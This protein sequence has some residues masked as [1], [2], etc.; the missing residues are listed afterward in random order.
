[1]KLSNTKIVLIIILIS[2]LLR[3]FLAS[4]LELGNDEVYYWTYALYPDWSHYDHP[5]MVGLFIQLFSLNLSLD[6]EFFIRLA[7]I[8]SGSFCAYLIYLIAKEIKDE[9]TGLISVLLYTSSFYATVITGVFILPDTPLCLFWLISLNLM[10][11]IIK[12][13]SSEKLS[14]KYLILLGFTIVFAILSKY[15]GI[16][17]WLG[18][19]SYLL[20][21]DRSKMRSRSFL[22]FN[23]ICLLGLAP[24]LYWNFTN[25]FASFQF[26]SGRIGLETFSFDGFFKELG[27]EL[28]YHNP[29]VYI[30]LWIGFFS[31]CRRRLNIQPK[32]I[33]LLFFISLPLIFMVFAV[34]LFRPS[35]PHWSGPAYLTLL[36]LPA[37]YI[38]QK[39]SVKL[40]YGLISFCVLILFSGLAI[41]YSQIK[42][43]LFKLDEPHSMFTKGQNDPSLDMVGWEQLADQFALGYQQDLKDKLI[44]KNTVLISDRWFPAAHLDYYV[45][46][47]LGLKL[48]LIGSIEDQHKYHWINAERGSMAIG[49]DAYYIT[50]ST[51]YN[52]PKDYFSEYFEFID[53]SIGIPI[54][55]N[56]EIVKYAFVYHLHSLKKNLW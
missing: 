27:G 11:N 55:R 21:Y 43:G 51:M 20:F 3:G 28:I 46:R 4:V 54:L 37:I 39:S 15:S 52:N 23:L 13:D 18:F 42:N 10:L 44:D 35:L 33:R 16:L 40:R 8:V 49:D 50:L 45:A 7:S 34:S 24:I 25:D 14:S 32:Y 38:Q 41:G 53:L 56:D 22:I 1:M 48:L 9:K 6:S 2:A 19:V 12:L 29:L 30:L 17:L 47:P 5:P 36:I 31:W 26:H